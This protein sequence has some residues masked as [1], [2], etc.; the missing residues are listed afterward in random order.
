MPLPVL[1][2]PL[3]GWPGC[4]M[5]AP[6]APSV[7]DAEEARCVNERE[8]ELGRTGMGRRVAVWGSAAE[9]LF[10]TESA[11]GS[12]CTSA[13]LP[14]VSL[15]TSSHARLQAGTCPARCSRGQRTGTVLGT[16]WPGRMFRT[17][18]AACP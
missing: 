10:K 6:G 15:G 18:R 2:Q 1:A 14:S 4:E 7:V 3:A 16:P 8:A 12:L 13:V 9:N 5:H 17:W 11:S